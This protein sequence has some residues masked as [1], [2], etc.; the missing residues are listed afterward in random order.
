MN[1]C[2]TCS[3]TA[4]LACSQCLD[5][6]Y[7]S[8]ECAD[9]DWNTNHHFKYCQY[10]VGGG[11]ALQGLVA[12]V[13]IHVGNDNP[14]TTVDGWLAKRE[15]LANA[16]AQ[17]QRELDAYVTTKEDVDSHLEDV[18]LLTNLT[19]MGPIV[20][21]SQIAGYGLFA[22]RR[23][24]GSLERKGQYITTYDG[25]KARA[26]D[27]GPYVLHISE[28]TVID[29]FYGF[30]LID[31]GR[32]INHNDNDFNVYFSKNQVHV[33]TPEWEYEKAPLIEKGTEL[34]INYG[35]DYSKDW[36]AKESPERKKPKPSPF[37]SHDNPIVI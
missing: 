37:G 17:L 21:Q 30:Q 4:F 25:T 20:M 35:D 27:S 28:Q 13:Q 8:E 9:Y 15:A 24:R 6:T 7:C 26:G 3:R 1:Y 18:V 34:I 33:F 11:G 10:P 36:E 22:D 31:K 29:G 19:S 5:S 32:W 16:D 2:Q 12:R 23:Y 14:I